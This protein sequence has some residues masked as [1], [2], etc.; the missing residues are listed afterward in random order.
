MIANASVKKASMA[1]G[2]P[3]KLRT[4]VLSFMALRRPATKGAA[5]ISNRTTISMNE[6]AKAI[7]AG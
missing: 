4:I 5:V 1:K 6:S 2:P 3:A 7:S